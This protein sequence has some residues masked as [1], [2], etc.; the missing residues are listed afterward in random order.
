MNNNDTLPAGAVEPGSD[1]AREAQET[2]SRKAL[3]FDL[4]SRMKNAKTFW[5]PVRER[6][7]EDIKFA[8]GD[9]WQDAEE[10][11]ADAASDK[12]Q[13]NFVQRELNQEVSAIYAKNPTVTCERRKR[14]EYTVWD[15]TD[16]QLQQAQQ[17]LQEAAPMMQQ[18][19]QAQQIL[20]GEQ[21]NP[22]STPPEL[23]LQ[24][25]SAVNS[26]PAP[27]KMAQAV[28]NDYQQGLQRKALLDKISETAELVFNYQLDAQ[29]PDFESQMKDLILREKTTG[30][31]FVAVKF[32]RQNESVMTTSAMR[33]TIIDRLQ[34][35]NQLLEG[36]QE[37]E[38]QP[39]E[40]ET[41]N[42]E[43]ASLQKQL[44]N[45]Q[46]KLIME[47]IVL[48]FK[49]TSSILIDPKCRSL[50]K[51]LGAD[52][53]AEEFQLTPEQ[54]EAQWQV[55]VT[56]KAVTYQNGEENANQT[57]LNTKAG[58][59]DRDNK[60]SGNWPE[61]A[62]ACVWVI[63]DK[64]TQMQYT[65]CDGYPDFLEEPDSPWPALKGFWP[66]VALKLTRLEVE[67]NNPKAGITIFG[68]S[69]VRLMRP[70]QEEFNRSQEALREH[71]IANKPGHICGKDTF[72]KNDRAAL[73]ARGAHDVIPLNNVQ[74]GADVSKVL[75]PIPTIP[76]D[77]ALYRTDGLMQM[78]M[79]V[80][81]TQQANLGQQQA[82]EK[83][84]GQAIAEQSRIS[85]VS[86]EVDSLDKFLCE[87]AGIMGEMLFQEMS[88]ET[89][90]KIA[91]PGG[92][93][94]NDPKIR[95]AVNETLTLKIEA[96]SMGRPNRAMEI[97]NLQTMMPQL[98]QLAQLMGLSMAPLVK[99]AS[100]VLEF[101]FDIDEWLASAQP[102]QQ[103]GGQGGGGKGLS[104]S[105]SI[106]L[107][108]LTTG[109]RA[110]ALQMA[111]I[112]ATPGAVSTP[113]ATPAP[114]N[115]TQPQQPG[116]Q[117]PTAPGAQLVNAQLKKAGAA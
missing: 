81:G 64:T 6:I 7:L 58:G 73:S 48:D 15:G 62:H 104:E 115:P 43:I 110:Q 3:V 44:Q 33:A 82:G 78:V 97:S 27:V 113:N 20:Q 49:P 85:G 114:A 35:I 14:M 12:F 5:K 60:V 108:D 19:G 84:T 102:Q 52:W 96:G 28:V 37:D 8:G 42:L 66:I 50:F 25:Q 92:A 61:K 65:I 45:P 23:L 88:L 67:E 29:Q 79:L 103:Q 91:G 112:Q 13:V 36:K 4:T 74:P 40:L 70:M 2:E 111:G 107:P 53:I 31:G 21:Q 117:Q 69:A 83:A 34:E 94:A 30:A 32:Q 24:A 17:I 76:I 46:G 106:K 10:K 109:E 93:W 59:S 116:Q 75:A 41:L 68:Q 98:V 16:G 105:L 51:F 101:D 100:K 26:I 55:D 80:V 57:N 63:Y 89:A 72:D 54:I 47:G 22:G 95:Q 87:L 38:L 77:P 56:D 39:A 18:I 71:R 9:Q 99:Y 86:S 90:Q 11:E 1:E